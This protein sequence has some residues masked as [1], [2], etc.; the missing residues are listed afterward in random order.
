MSS[1]DPSRDPG[2]GGSKE[3][4]LLFVPLIRLRRTGPKDPLIRLR[5]VFIA[6]CAAVLLTGVVLFSMNL[7]A[8][9]HR[10]ASPVVGAGAVTISAAICL[11]MGSRGTARPL[12]CGSASS[13]A[14]S[15]R[16][17][18]FVRVAFSEAP[19]LLGSVL[20]F[21]T[22]NRWPYVLGASCMAVGLAWLTPTKLHLAGEQ[23]RLSIQ[24]CEHDLVR[25]LRNLD[26]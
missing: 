4:A 25:A 23:A 8:R 10:I 26:A 16:Q 24:G 3:I 7:G 18:F 13:L 11:G 21:L 2:W 5:H 15:Y 14:R 6:F 19:M 9:R 12:D 22:R 17:R 1:G 20:V